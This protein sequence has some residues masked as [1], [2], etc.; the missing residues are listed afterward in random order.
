MG[1]GRA[2]FQRR[3]AI[4]DRGRIADARIEGQTRRGRHYLRVTVSMTVTAPDV[5][6]ALLMA[7]RA[8]RRAA[9]DDIEGWDVG[10]A[11]A[12]Y[13]RRSGVCYS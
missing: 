6:Q 2:G 12:E 5:S 3:L 4:Q 9:G 11:S 7:W 10:S 8:F 1:P 13:G